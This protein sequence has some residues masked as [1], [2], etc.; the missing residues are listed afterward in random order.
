[1]DAGRLVAELPMERFRAGIKRLQVQGA[2]VTV[3]SPPPFLLLARE[4]NG[5]IGESWVVRD[6]GDGMTDYFVSIG[7]TLREIVDLD[8]E[9]G[10]VEL[11]RSF[12]TQR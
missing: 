3:P 8:L 10:Y 2:P 1:M 12:R 9:D 7:A 11:L 5:G 6:W 4:R